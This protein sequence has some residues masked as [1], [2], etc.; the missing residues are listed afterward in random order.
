MVSGSFAYFFKHVE[1]AFA[2]SLLFLMNFV[3]VVCWLVAQ[4]AVVGLVVAELAD[5]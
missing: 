4:V 2:I 5:R 3:I 1:L